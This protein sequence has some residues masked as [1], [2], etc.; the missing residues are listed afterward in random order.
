MELFYTLKYWKNS[1]KYPNK[2]KNF[3]VD[4]FDSFL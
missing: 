3:I 4:Y 2:T 1:R